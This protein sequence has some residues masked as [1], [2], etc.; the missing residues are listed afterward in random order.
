MKYTEEWLT[1]SRN[2]VYNQMT[3]EDNRKSSMAVLTK[4]AERTLEYKDCLHA[5]EFLK[6]N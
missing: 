4:V 1:K 3:K 5:K 6:E 2:R